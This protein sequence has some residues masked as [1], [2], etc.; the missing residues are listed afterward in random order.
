MMMVLLVQVTL[1][2][3][4]FSPNTS[5]YYLLFIIPSLLNSKVP[6][7][8]SVGT[9]KIEANLGQLALFSFHR[10][11]VLGDF[12][13]R[14]DRLACSKPNVY[15]YI[16]RGREIERWRKRSLRELS[17]GFEKPKFFFY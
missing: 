12:G 11:K 8:F 7:N 4:L 13:L 2:E 14:Y 1:R 6:Q 3:P 10:N 16:V 17:R 5:F 15:V 9:R